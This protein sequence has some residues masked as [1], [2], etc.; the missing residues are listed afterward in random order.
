MYY[1]L[2]LTSSH[3]NYSP[4][5]IQVLHEEEPAEGRTPENLSE[6]FKLRLNWLNAEKIAALARV[7]D[8]V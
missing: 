7:S 5:S 8:L 2:P 3:I 6:S 4:L 1:G